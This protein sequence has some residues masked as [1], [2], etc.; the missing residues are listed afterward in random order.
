MFKPTRQ[1]ISAHWTPPRSSADYLPAVGTCP[2]RTSNGFSLWNLETV[3]HGSVEHNWPWKRLTTSSAKADWTRHWCL[4]QL[5]VLL[6]IC[7]SPFLRDER[8]FR[9]RFMLRATL[10]FLEV[11]SLLSFLCRAKRPPTIFH[12]RGT[13]PCFSFSCNAWRSVAVI[14]AQ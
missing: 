2:M 8:P 13:D 5:N 9:H 11:G 14:C 3:G 4:V 6:E 12:I 10:P 1:I 7:V